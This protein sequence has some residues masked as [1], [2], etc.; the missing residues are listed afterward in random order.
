MGS[1]FNYKTV[2]L[3][4][5]F[6]P[7]KNISFGGDLEKRMKQEF[8]LF[9]I[10]W[11]A[12]ENAEKLEEWI[13]FTNVQIHRIK[14]EEEFLN[15]IKGTNKTSEIIITTGS[16]A[17]KA[18][19]KINEIHK[20]SCII[21]IYCMNIDYHK[22][23]SEKYK[24]VGG[25]FSHPSQIFE[26]LLKFQNSV[27]QMPSFTYKF[28]SYEEFNLNYYD[29]YNKKELSIDK[30]TFSLIL[31][32]YEKFCIRRLNYFSLAFNDSN[33]LYH[34]FSNSLELKQIFYDINI[35]EHML[36]NNPLDNT[37]KELINF[38][39][40]L[41]LV[42]LYFS[43]FA[44][45]YGYLNY[46]ETTTILNKEITLKNF[47]DDY[48]ELIK[49]HLPALFTKLI[50]GNV[51]ILEENI[52]LKF[53]HSF[54]IKFAKLNATTFMTEFK[55][56]NFNRFPSMVKYLMDI[57]FCL[58]YFFCNIYG[59]F[60]DKNLYISL[61]S[62][63]MGI[64]KRIQNYD[65][66]FCLNST[67]NI[68]LNFVNDNDFST[69]NESLKIVDFIVI[70]DTN[71]HQKIKSI[72]NNFT[73]KK[74]PYLSMAE[75]KSYLIS[76]KQAK[77]RNFAYF[78]IIDIK[79]MQNAFKEL[80]TLRNEFALSLILI[81]YNENEKILINKRPLQI[82]AHMSMF[83]ANNTNEI[84]N[85]INCQEFINCG[86]LFDSNSSDAITEYQKNID[87]NLKI[88]KIEME[89]ENKVEK[90]NTEDGWE[91]VDKV[92]E[93]IFKKLIIGF[94]GNFLMTDSLFKSMFKLYKDNKIDYLFYQTY[95]KYFGLNL[96][97]TG[98]SI[99]V[100]IKHFIY[101][102]TLDE[103][104]NSFYY[105]MNKELRSG[106]PLKVN[107]YL[108]IISGI[109]ST[110]EDKTLNCIKSYEGKLFRATKMEEKQIDEKIIPGKVLTN[111]SFWSASKNRKTAENFLA[112]KE[113]NILFLIETKG[114]NIDIDY[115]QISKFANEE[116]VLFLPYSKFL[117]KGKEKKLFKNK[118]IYEVELEGLDQNDRENIKNVNMKDFSFVISNVMKMEPGH[119]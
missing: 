105:L 84:I 45:L 107:K 32:N 12:P 47:R 73:H 55:F 109:N 98:E 112:G 101:A 59:Y 31:N 35:L 69:L 64:D 11:C 79:D 117:I 19:S 60:K 74:I 26:F 20:L 24:C 28:Y 72:E 61:T 33:Y 115:E 43:K 5:Y 118:E 93:E 106:D 108:E 75:V 27:F 52:H 9:N 50:Q 7:E 110:F 116:E 39:S 85:Y 86:A 94:C 56:E 89:N 25:V 48:K 81:I 111:L 38:L 97:Q 113:K 41:T 46:D 16:Y 37:T 102:Y 91:L 13:A 36:I 82:M 70:G 18:I 103:G 90:S 54:L 42:A 6:A 88:P 62:S 30:F 2:Q 29:S 34:F 57:D 14:N 44:Y 21:L 114:K 1:Y 77:Y 95:C 66:Y 8:N 76:K 4:P 100:T 119:P 99:C 17:E 23:W 68:A 63:I 96:M 40:E 83:I 49:I 53:L 3:K 58:K 65:F 51:S 71:F 22:K 80:Y 87:K 10:F 15:I 92:P 104:K 67:K 78:I